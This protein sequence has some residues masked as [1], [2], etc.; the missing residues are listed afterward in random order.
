ML[1][2]WRAREIAQSAML[3]LPS[4]HPGVL[5][6][7]PA[8]SSSASSSTSAS[9]ASASSTAL[10][11]ASTQSTPLVPVVTINAEYVLT[12][13]LS[14]QPHVTLFMMLGETRRALSPRKS[15]KPP[16]V[17]HI[18]QS[19][20]QPLIIVIENMQWSDSNSWHLARYGFPHSHTSQCNTQPCSSPVLLNEFSP[21]SS[22]DIAAC[23]P[24]CLFIMTLRPLMRPYPRYFEG[25]KNMKQTQTI[26]LEVL[27]KVQSLLRCCATAS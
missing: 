19:T 21:L 14:T 8:P 5:P 22:R 18:P 13:P 17:Q 26:V 15:A 2:M 6:A 24:N 16:K 10:V 20:P 23:I 12:H 3:S 7:L 9:S 11:P 1:V 4:D 27:S 25:I